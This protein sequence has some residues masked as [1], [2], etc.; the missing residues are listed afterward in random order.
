MSSAARE[1]DLLAAS[2]NHLLNLQRKLSLAQKPV[3]GLP[4]L[5]PIA[6][7]MDD[8]FNG[9][10]LTRAKKSMLPVDAYN[11]FSSEK[12]PISEPPRVD[13]FMGSNTRLIGRDPKVLY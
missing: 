1:V 10:V 2:S 3:Y 12:Y 8:R 9:G 11:R 6:G 5:N 13:I 4:P 7:R